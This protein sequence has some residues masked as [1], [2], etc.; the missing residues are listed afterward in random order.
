[1][2]NKSLLDLSSE[3]AIKDTDILSYFDANLP[4]K[5]RHQI[6]RSI[7]H[8]LKYYIYS[9]T[10][11]IQVWQNIQD[12]ISTKNDNAAFR[13]LVY[14]LMMRY[15]STQKHLSIIERHTF[16]QTIEKDPFQDIAELQLRL[17]SLSVLTDE[18][19]KISGIEN[20]V[21]PLLSSWFNQYL[22]WQ[23]QATELQGKDADSKLAHLLFFKSLFKF[24]TN[25]VKFQ[26]FLVPEAQLLQLVNSVV[27]I[28]NHARLEDVVTE[29]LMFF[30]SMIRYSVIPKAS[31]YDTVLILCSTYIST[32]SYSKLAQSVIFNLISSPVSNLA[33]ENVFNI[34]QYN[35]SNVNAVRGAVRLMRFLMLQEVKNDAIASITLSSSIEF[36]EFPLGFNENVDFEILGTVYLFLRTPSILNRLNFL[37]WHRILNILMYCSQYLPLKASTSKEA[38]SKTAAFANIYD[39]VLDFLDFEALIPLLQQFQVKLVFFLKDVLPVL[40][41]KIR[42]K[43]LR[44]F[45][46]YNLIFP[47]NQYWVFNL[48]FLL[49]IYQ[50]KTFDLEDRA[51]LFKLV[52]DACS[53]AD[54]NS[55][56][57]LCSK[58]LFPVIESFSTESDD[59]VVSPVYNML[60]FLSV[61]FQNPGLKDCID[62]IFQQLISDTSSVTVRRLATSTLIRLFYYYYDL[63]D[64]VPIQETLAKMLEILETPSFPFVSRMLCLQFFLRFRANGTSIYICENID[65]NEPFKVLNVDSEL[66]PAVYP[67]SDSFVNS[68]TVEKHIW[69]RK[70]N[71]LIKISNHSTEYG[72]DFVTFPTSSLLRFYRKSMATESNWTILMFMITHLADQISNRS[73]F[74]GALE[75]IYNLLDFMCDIV[76]E[77]VSISAEI[78][79]NIRKANIM[80][81][82]LQNVQMLFVYHDQFSRAQEDELVSVFFAGLQKWNEACHVSIH[83]LMLCCYELPVSIRKQLPAILVTLSRLITKP[84]L[85]VHILEFLCSLARLPDLIANFTD[86]DYRQIFAIA[87]KY[88]QHRDFTKESKDSNDTESILKNSYSSYVLALAYS[89]LQIWFLSLRLTERKKFVPWILRGLKLASEGKPLEDLCLVQYDMMQ[90]FCYSNSDINNQTSTFV[91]S[92]VESETWIRG[93]SLFTINVSVNSGF[94]EAVIRRP[95]GTTQYTFRNE[96]SLQKFLWEEN[97]TSSKALTRGLLCTPSSFVSHFLDP[98]GISLYNQPLL[99]PS[100]DD[101]VRRAISVF[102]R[103]PVIE[104]LKAGLV[105]VGYQQRREADILANTNPSEDFLTFLNGLGTLF[106]LKTDQKVFAGGLDREND[107][108]GAFAYCWKDKVTQMV[109]HCT[110]MMPTNIEHDPGCTLK[111][112]HIGNDFV[113][114][115]F[116]ESGLEYDFDTI[117]SQFNFVNI[118]ITPESESIR[119]TGRQIKFYKVKALTK[120]DI[121]FSLFRRY[122]IVSSDALPA[123]VRD[124]TLN[125]AVFS[126]IYHRSAGDY[127]H[128][129]AERLRQLKRLR[130]KFQASVLPEDYNL[131]E[132]TKTKLQNGTNFSDFTS[133]L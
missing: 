1:M 5:K 24:S 51:L 7:Y 96:A 107:I 79:S 99:L 41:P 3:P 64:A 81:P 94:L 16:F 93:N 26:W 128:I 122:K 68:A 111:K 65:L 116:N 118:V 49:G 75:E 91:D 80:I 86:A 53:V 62:H 23:S 73:M 61:N 38:F 11:I 101:S 66:I 40:K 71:D 95:T 59:S 112:R 28:C 114:I 37:D 123:I 19:H 6:V 35:R 130:E 115:I 102:D 97:L 36:T 10:S 43:L 132:Q 8:G 45:E 133:Y 27:Q 17:K 69:E 76:F 60:F 67:I 89:V 15:V 88:I 106:E 83:S 44:L 77:R 20:R 78:P 56:P 22:Q 117:P 126:H 52:E 48:E 9:S 33:F 131:D 124:V 109:F 129:W 105:Y 4:F 113:T 46:T 18:G 42:K 30:D 127:V 82:F 57:I 39:R 84:D 100:N 85:S 63:R 98:H 13:E 2:N 50:C 87:L 108:D 104:S 25:L 125:A 29:V 12:F 90:Q 55:A 21:G 47:C 14:N 121:D 120:Y 58:F 72:K 54:E 70:E 119:R 32:Y 74:I 110:T 34:L 92:D 103:I 31:L